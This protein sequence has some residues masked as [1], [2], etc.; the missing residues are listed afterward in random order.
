MTTSPA[1]RI[2]H[3]SL[4]NAV[5]ITIHNAPP[6]LANP[7]DPFGTYSSHQIQPHEPDPL[8]PCT[9]APNPASPE[10]AM[11]R[12]D[13]EFPAG[14]PVTIPA[15]AFVPVSGAETL[16]LVVQLN[17][18][19][20]ERDEARDL[21]QKHSDERDEAV[22][23]RHLL[24]TNNEEI[25]EICRAFGKPDSELTAE[26]LRHRL[27]RA[28]QNAEELSRLASGRACPIGWALHQLLEGRRVARRG[29]NG[30]GMWLAYIPSD[31]WSAA[32][33]DANIHL[34]RLPWIGMKTADGAFV[35]WH[36]SQTDLLATD[37]CL[38]E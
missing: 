19:I 24:Q 1:Q 16:R 28:Q 30:K 18:A 10:F 27:E 21:G 14:P 7:G 15:G 22:A 25:R 38:A 8:L 35:P 29:W 32:E 23:A 11:V 4:P 34:R 17:A 36:C 6:P 37:W 31:E 3:E 13:P 12:A 33:P 20:R 26:W 9:W 5:R 2:E